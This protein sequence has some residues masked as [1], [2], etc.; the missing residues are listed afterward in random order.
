[1]DYIGSGGSEARAKA[2]LAKMN[3]WIRM[4]TNEQPGERSSTATGIDRR[5]PDIG[6]GTSV[7]FE[8]PFGAAAMVDASQ[9]GLAGRH[10]EP[11]QRRQPR[12]TTA[13]AETIRLLSLLVMSGHWWAAVNQLAGRA[14]SPSCAYATR[15]AAPCRRGRL[16]SVPK[17][18]ASMPKA[19]WTEM[20]RLAIGMSV[21]LAGPPEP[22]WG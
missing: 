18:L 5:Q 3:T 11:H 9:P 14:A 22:L 21:L 13:N 6:N 19:C 16:P 2:A 1:M 15:P 4:K 20:N 7:V 17:V 8:G 10:L 12:A